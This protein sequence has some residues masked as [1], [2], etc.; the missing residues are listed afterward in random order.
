M[1]QKTYNYRFISSNKLYSCDFD[2]LYSNII[3]EDAIDRICDYIKD[4]FDDSLITI[5]GFRKL[6]QILFT[7]NYFIFNNQI[8]KQNTG[9]AMGTI[10]APNIAN[11][12]VY[13]LEKNFLHIHKP[14]LYY[15]YIDDIFIITEQNFNI[16]LLINSFYNL[17]LNVVSEFIINFLNLNISLCKLTGK[18]IFSI[19]YKSTNTFSYLL[20]TSN[21]NK[22]IFDNIPFGLFFTIKRIC[23]YFHDY[24]FFS[25]KIFFQLLKRGYNYKMLRKIMNTVSNL[26]RNEIIPYKNK[27]DKIRKFQTNNKNKFTFKLPF[28]INLNDYHIKLNSSFNK[29]IRDYN[30]IFSN[31][32]DINNITTLEIEKNNT[33]TIPTLNIIYTRNLSISD[34]FINNFSIKNSFYNFKYKECLDPKCLYCFFA[35]KNSSIML[36]NFPLYVKKDS[37]CT[38][39]DCIYI[40]KCSLCNTFYVGKTNNIKKR[41]Y[42][43]LN[44]ILKFKQYINYTNVSIHFNLKDHNIFKHFSFII[45]NN[46]TKTDHLDSNFDNIILSNETYYIHLFKELNMNLLNDI[47]PNRSFITNHK[48][49][50]YE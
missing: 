25:R 49:L 42:N 22:K 38:S 34:I 23:T 46:F 35:I 40:I 17:K 9:I 33:K 13:T 27:E 15:R 4:I 11:I 48:I 12:Y 47:I 5:I 19:F 30:S 50:D 16:N 3:L 14:L 43:H 26:N 44:D 10:S 28:N 29:A 6:L 2:S 1:I 24:L 20:N 39:L 37:T 41:L 31:F 8:Y 45:I 36:N 7:N 18:L 32:S 21:H